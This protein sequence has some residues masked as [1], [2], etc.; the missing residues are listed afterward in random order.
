ML[1]GAQQ[2]NRH[3]LY[4]FEV[5]DFDNR[6]SETGERQVNIKQLWQ[7]SH[8][9]IVLALQGYK[10]TEI[11]EIL[12]IHP[13]TVSNTLNSELGMKKLSELREDRDKGV[14][15][16]SKRVAE[17]S[18]IA[19]DMYE[20]IFNCPDVDYKLKKETADTVLMDI[21]GHRAPTK[22]DTRSVHTTATMAQIEEFKQ[23]G[24]QAARE[25]GLLITVDET[26][27]SNNE[28]PPSP[29]PSTATSTQSMSP[30]GDGLSEQ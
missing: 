26:Q 24:L 2:V 6:R 14:V 28:P 13:Q 15:D 19:L 18:K 25:S 23:R 11:A 21:G 22:I 30:S 8:E 29:S 3:S 12:N 7:R 20:E 5:R 10:Q 16:V 27:A 1:D 4:G 17:L 9:I